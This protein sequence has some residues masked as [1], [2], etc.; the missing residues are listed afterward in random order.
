[1]CEASAAVDN[2]LDVVKKQVDIVT[3]GARGAGVSELIDQLIETTWN[4]LHQQP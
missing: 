3:G 4:I 1:M 2:A